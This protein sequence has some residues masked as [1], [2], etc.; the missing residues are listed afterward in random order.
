MWYLN[1]NGSRRLMHLN[2]WP[3]DGG[4]VWKG[5]GGVASLGE[6]GMSQGFEV[7]KAHAVPSQFAR[8]LLFVD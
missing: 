8:C 1:H 7:S 3:L 5:L 6:G 4:N 2:T